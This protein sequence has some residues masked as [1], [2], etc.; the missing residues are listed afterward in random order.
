MLI[1]GLLEAGGCGLAWKRAATHWPRSVM[2]GL[3]DWKRMGR[4]QAPTSFSRSAALQSFLAVGIGRGGVAAG[5][6]LH[7]ALQTLHVGAA[8]GGLFDV[9]RIGRPCALAARD[10]ERFEATM[11]A[12]TFHGMIWPHK[13]APPALRACSHREWAA[14]GLFCLSTAPAK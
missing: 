5:G 6:F 14:Q 4:A 1:G 9:D 7:T 12:G 3:A 13:S 8:G 10:G 2:A 11:M